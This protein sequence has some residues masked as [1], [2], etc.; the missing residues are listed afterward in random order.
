M[1]S[2][3]ELVDHIW[4]FKVEDNLSWKFC[5]DILKQDRDIEISPQELKKRFENYFKKPQS[6]QKEQNP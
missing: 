3:K 1:I 2:D 4:H 5:A 6:K